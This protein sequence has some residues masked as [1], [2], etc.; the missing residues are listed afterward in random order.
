M[1]TLSSFEAG[2]FDVILCLEYSTLA[3]LHQLFAH[4]RRLKPR[5]VVLDLATSNRESTIATFHYVFKYKSHGE[6][7][8][9]EQQDGFAA[10]AAA[11]S[12]SLIK[13]LCGYFG[14]KCEAIDWTRIGTADRV[15]V[16]DYDTG[17]RRTYVLER[18]S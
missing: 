3:D 14:F 12:H 18:T 2:A 10:L 11:P 17:L 16:G 5:H 9:D 15:G 6:T 13:L 8:A 1:P 4:F 7:R